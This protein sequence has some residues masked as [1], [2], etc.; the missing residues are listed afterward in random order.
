LTRV[1]GNSGSPGG[2]AGVTGIAELRAITV[3]P[4]QFKHYAKPSPVI[5]NAKSGIIGGFAVASLIRLELYDM[6]PASAGGTA[7]GR[8]AADNQI[9][10]NVYVIGPDEK[11]KPV[12]SYPMT[13]GRNFD[14][15]LRA[16]DSL[17]LTSN[18]RLASPVNWKQGD[19]VIIAE[20]VSNDEAR[21]LYP[22]RWKE[23]QI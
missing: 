7:D 10:R 15:V 20:S 9:V 23:P 14:E 17:Q 13:T 16:I 8:T 18:H 3:T 6:L 19:D 4:Y 22:Q 11:I 5:P 1:G 12:I 2:G 21:K